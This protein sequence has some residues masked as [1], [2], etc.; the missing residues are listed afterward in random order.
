MVNNTSPTNNQST[1]VIGSSS[2]SVP[3]A[4]SAPVSSKDTNSQQSLG[5]WRRR[6][7]NSV[8]PKEPPKV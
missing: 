1:S 6:S 4:T 5:V 2:K 3:A 7:G 8:P